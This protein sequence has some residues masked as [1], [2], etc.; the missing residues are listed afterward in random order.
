MRIGTRRAVWLTTALL[1]AFG[2]LVGCGRTQLRIGWLEAGGPGHRTAQYRTFS[3]V[4]RVRFRAGANETVT[5][6]Y[7]ITVEKGSLTLSLVGPDGETVW[8]ETFEEREGEGSESSESYSGEHAL[9]PVPQSGRY[10]L[11]IEGDRTGGRF[12]VSWQVDEG[13]EGGV[14]AA[15]AAVA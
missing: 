1:A 12:D 15:A 5:I 7:E 13:Q 6:D 11:R 2:L 9:D 14:T 10:T 4:E 3:G 8:E